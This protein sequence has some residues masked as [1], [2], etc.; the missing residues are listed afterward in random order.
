MNYLTHQLLNS[1]EIK[2]VKENIFLKDLPWEDGKKTAGN[3]AAKVKNNLQLYK[4]SNISKKYTELIEKKNT[5]QCS[6]KKFCLT[7][8]DTWNNVY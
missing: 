3:H 7:K 8:K 6:N 1:Q 5:Q 4:S 2:L